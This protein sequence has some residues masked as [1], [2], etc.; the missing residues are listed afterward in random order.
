LT[1]VLEE[2]R[3][4][5][6]ELVK[7]KRSEECLNLAWL[8]PLKFTIFHQESLAIHGGDELAPINL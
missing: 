3:G 4:P 5:A 1:G 6:G 2:R 7:E 8:I